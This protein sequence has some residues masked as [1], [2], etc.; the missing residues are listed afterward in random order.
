[1]GVTASNCCGENK[2]KDTQKLM[3][4]LLNKVSQLSSVVVVVVVV[5]VVL[6]AV[7]FD[8]VSV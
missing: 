6:V 8:S 4:R 3:G 5:D 2:N 7:I 1:M